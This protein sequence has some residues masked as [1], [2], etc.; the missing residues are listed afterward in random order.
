MVCVCVYKI[1]ASMCV[2][3]YIYIYI[4]TCMHACLIVCTYVC[5][6]R[7]SIY[8]CLLL[9][10][11]K[12]GFIC[13]KQEQAISPLSGKPPKLVNH[14]TYLGSSISSTESGINIKYGR[15]LTGYELYGN[16]ITQIK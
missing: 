4:Y 10:V 9:N 15:Q 6:L 14:F 7:V 8:I 1:Y 11:N 3:V 12:T 16:L 13:F 2:S 5:F